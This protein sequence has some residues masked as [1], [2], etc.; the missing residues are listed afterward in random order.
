MKKLIWILFTV[1]I[2]GCSAFSA[3]PTLTPALPY[4]TLTPLA[5]T[6]DPYNNLRA[7]IDALQASVQ[8]LEAQLAQNGTA[9]AQYQSEIDSLHLLGTQTALA[10]T[11]TIAPTAQY[12]STPSNIMSVVATRS[13]VNLRRIKNYNLAGYP[14]MV[15]QEPRVQYLEGEIFYVFIPIVRADGGDTFYQVYGPRGSG[16]YV[17]TIDVSKVE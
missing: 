1:L 11:P 13:K 17:R 10:L 3:A 12:T 9:I 15:I 16:L 2:V 8:S 5:A 4:E 6:A 7:E 14:I